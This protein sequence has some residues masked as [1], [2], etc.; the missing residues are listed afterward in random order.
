MPQAMIVAHPGG[1]IEIGENSEIS[2]YSRVAATRYVKIG[3]NVLTGPHVFICDYNHEYRDISKPIMR[4]GR[5]YNK[6]ITDAPLLEIGD[7]S[8]LGTN[9][10]IV[11]NVK[12][13]RNCV[14]GANSVVTHDIPDYCVAAGIPARVIKR[15]NQNTQQWEKT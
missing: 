6:E 1:R 15:F 7:G 2:M 8:W 12:I 9:A 10:V 14:I 5:M 11:G 4:Q 3:N 13:G